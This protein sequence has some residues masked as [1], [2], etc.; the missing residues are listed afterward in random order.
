[1]SHQERRNTMATMTELSPTARKSE[2]S[3]D[4]QGDEKLISRKVNSDLS[5][6]FLRFYRGFFSAIQ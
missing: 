6:W 2:Y 5:A 4:I 3:Q 1:M